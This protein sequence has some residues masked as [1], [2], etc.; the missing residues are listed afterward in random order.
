MATGN[1]SFDLTQFYNQEDKEYRFY[2]SLDTTIVVGEGEHYGIITLQDK[3]QRK[4]EVKLTELIQLAGYMPYL[5]VAVDSTNVKIVLEH[6]LQGVE[7]NIYINNL[8]ESKSGCQ[9]CK[10]HS[11]GLFVYI[12]NHDQDKCLLNLSWEDKVK[13]FFSAAYKRINHS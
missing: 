2:L 10:A 1:A 6:G 8:V 11:S 13:K 5:A 3:N 4:F 9:N 12:S 7:T